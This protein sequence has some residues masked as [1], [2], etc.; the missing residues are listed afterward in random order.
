MFCHLFSSPEYAQFWVF[1]DTCVSLTTFCCCRVSF[2][3][4]LHVVSALG[5]QATQSEACISAA[6]YE[7]LP[8]FWKQRCHCFQVIFTENK[9]KWKTNE[10]TVTFPKKLL[11]FFFF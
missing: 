4:A 3:I 8:F 10:N 11:H 6:N 2:C 1:C 7:L 5:A 9:M